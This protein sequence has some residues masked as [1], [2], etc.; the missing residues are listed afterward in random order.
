MV[1][2]LVMHDTVHVLFEFALCW[3][4]FMKTDLLISFKNIVSRFDQ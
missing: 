2:R 1:I 3:H 4:G